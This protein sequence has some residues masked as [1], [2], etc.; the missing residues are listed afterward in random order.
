MHFRHQKFQTHELHNLQ[1]NEVVHNV[2]NHQL[3]NLQENQPVHDCSFQ[4]HTFPDH[5]H[6][7][8]VLR[9]DFAQTS[10]NEIPFQQS[11]LKSPFQHGHV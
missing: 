3:H 4:G 1:K 6:F 11:A 9:N 2:P 7:P 10:P 5:C 8:I